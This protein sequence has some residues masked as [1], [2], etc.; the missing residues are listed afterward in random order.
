VSGSFS[1]TNKVNFKFFPS[2]TLVLV[3]PV[4]EDGKVTPDDNGKLLGL[5]TNY[6]L[7]AVPGQNWIFSNWVASGSETFVSYNPVLHFTMQTNLV[8]QANFVT[9]VFLAAQGTYN[10]LF[11]PAFSPR[12]QTNSGSFS[13]SVAR[14]GAVSGN[15]NL[16]GQSVPLSGRF[17]PAGTTNIV[18]RRANGK[19]SLT[20]ILQLDFTNQSVTGTVSDGGFLA[21]LNGDRNVF[22]SANKATEFEG[23]YTL[24]IPGT[25]NSN[26]GPFGVSHGTVSVSELGVITFV[27]SL[28]DGTA[29]TESSVVSKDGNWP[30]YLNLYGGNGSL[31]GWN[32]FSNHSILNTNPL[33]WI[34][35]TNSSRTAS[36]RLGFTNQEA[37]ITGGIYVPTN[38]LPSGLSAILLGSDLLIAITNGVD[39][40]AGD[41]ITLTNRLNETN[42]LTLTMTKSTGV[43]SGSF[44]NPA[45]PTQTI[46]VN[47]VILQAQTNAQGY[48]LGTNQSGIF[49]LT[50]Q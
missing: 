44:A 32:Y 14:T 5:G 42:K 27:G 22:T 48:F 47:G 49:I 1:A 9:N 46:R 37:T 43:I 39:F 13:F 50:S 7:T 8:L 30:F 45:K 23:Q 40:S 20:T 17:S 10:G 35:A 25:N 34:N 2:D 4:G 3:V 12:Q 29:I 41:K 21:R 33:S 19:P 24:I 28:A 38:P 11:A 18:S 15:L 16:A 31:W 36:Y 6:T 26:V